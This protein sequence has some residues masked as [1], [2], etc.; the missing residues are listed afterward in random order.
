MPAWGSGSP[1]DERG[2]WNLVHFI[3]HLPAQAPEELEEMEQM[4]PRTPDEFRE[5]EEIRRFLEGGEP[6]PAHRPMKH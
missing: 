4:N 5:E 3:R 6:A 1:E 2:S